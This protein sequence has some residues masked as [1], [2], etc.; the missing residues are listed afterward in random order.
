MA[1]F[2]LGAVR[3]ASVDQSQGITLDAYATAAY[4]QDDWKA[5]RRLT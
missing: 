4:L 3:S 5:T 1:S 2:V